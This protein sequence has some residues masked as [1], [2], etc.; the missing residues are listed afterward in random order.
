MNYAIGIWHGRRLDYT[1]LR[2][3]PTLHKHHAY[4][5]TYFTYQTLRSVHRISEDKDKVKPVIRKIRP[6]AGAVRCSPARRPA[7]S[8]FFSFLLLFLSFSFLF[9]LFLSFPFGLGLAVAVMVEVEVEV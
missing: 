7:L 4:L 9:S 2:I 3:I 6:G 5:L 8:H 1:Y